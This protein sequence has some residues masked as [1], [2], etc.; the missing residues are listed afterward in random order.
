MSISSLIGDTRGALNGFF[1]AVGSGLETGLTTVGSEILPNWVSGQLD[2][3]STDGLKTV[4]YDPFT[5][6]PRI[7]GQQPPP[8]QTAETEVKPGISLIDTQLFKIGDIA[9][10]GGQLM[11][12]AA[13]VGVLVFILKRV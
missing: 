11:L 1:G 7:G 3:Q 4:L 13:A 5:G 6:Q 9:I 10:T 8:I 12:M 2:M